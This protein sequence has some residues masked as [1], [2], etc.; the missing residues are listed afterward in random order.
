M[1]S[2]VYVSPISSTMPR[3]PP[4]SISSPI[5]TG[6]VNAIMSPAMKLPSVRCAAKPITIPSTAEEARIAAATARTCGITSSA[7]RTPTKT[8]VATIVRRRIR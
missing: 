5:R 8:I 7:E 6:C 4:T 1:R 2:H 3:A